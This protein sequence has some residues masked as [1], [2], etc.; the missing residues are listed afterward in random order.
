[1]SAWLR[2]GTWQSH[3]AALRPSGQTEVTEAFTD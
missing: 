2:M 1:M 3:A